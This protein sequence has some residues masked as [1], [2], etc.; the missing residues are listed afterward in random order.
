MRIN[1]IEEFFE[2]SVGK[3]SLTELSL[4]SGNNISLIN[5]NEQSFDFDNIDNPI[6]QKDKIKTSDTVYFKNGKIIFVEFK[7]GQRIPETD[8]RLKAIESI[9]TFYNYVFGNNFTDGLCFP[10]DCF[11]IYF[12][13]QKDNIRATALPFFSNLER[14][15]R[16]QYKHLISEYHIIESEEFKR[17][18]DI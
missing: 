4:D 16:I 7:R 14:K 3:K 18:F 2:N 9:I 5:S 12:I 17:L 10:N 15:F 8:F 1:D 13:Y 6:N 11:Q